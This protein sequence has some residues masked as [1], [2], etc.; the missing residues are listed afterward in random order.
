MEL[1]K[2]EN[3]FSLNLLFAYQYVLSFGIL[4][5]T[6][7]SFTW[8]SLKNSRFL[9]MKSETFASFVKSLQENMEKTFYFWCLSRDF[10]VWTKRISESIK[11]R[12]SYDKPHET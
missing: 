9:E 11:Q 1:D 2:F 7:F 4:L 12:Q 6:D 8:D 5:W 3:H 10:D